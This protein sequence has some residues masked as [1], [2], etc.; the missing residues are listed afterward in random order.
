[1]SHERLLV[2][3]TRLNGLLGIPHYSETLFQ[4]RNHKSVLETKNPLPMEASIF[5][6]EPGD[7]MTASGKTRIMPVG[8]G[9]FFFW[10]LRFKNYARG[11]TVR[12]GWEPNQGCIK[13]K[14]KVVLCV[15]RA[16]KVCGGRPGLG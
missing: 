2:S 13:R 12:K 10:W 7:Q 4:R 15:R 1:M 5:P 3:A 14:S 9:G 16:V 6:E 8:T 11:R